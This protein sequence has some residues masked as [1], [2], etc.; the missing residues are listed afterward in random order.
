MISEYEKI[1]N[2]YKS[3]VFGNPQ[4]IYT[5]NYWSTPIRSSIDEQVSN[6]VDKNRLVIEN[7]THIH[8][9]MNLEIACSPGILLGEMCDNGFECIGIEVDS[10]YKKQIEKYSKRA[11]LFFGFFPTISKKWAS[12]EF[13]NIIAL[14]VFE[15]IE[16]S[17]GFLEE[18]NRLMVTGGHLIIQS[19]IILEDGQMDDKMFNGL[20]H[21]WIYGIEDLKELLLKN[22]FEVLKVDRHKVGHEQIVAKKIK[23]YG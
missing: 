4:D 3:K 23:S 7:L 22:G 9:V 17:N 11:E 21:I 16:D 12:F 20:E 19:P 6:V 10:K 13:S 14:D 15:H 8:P 5:D 18:C 2:S 1:G